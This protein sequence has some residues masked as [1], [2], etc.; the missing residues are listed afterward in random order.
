MKTEQL[1]AEIDQILNRRQE[2]AFLR[3]VLAL[4]VA[5]DKIWPAE[6]KVRALDTRDLIADTADIG[7]GM[8]EKAHALITGLY[9]TYFSWNFNDPERREEACKDICADL[10]YIAAILWAADG[11]LFE[12]NRD[13]SA[14]LG[15]ETGPVKAFVQNTRKL[16]GEFLDEAAQEEGAAEC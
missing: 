15:V 5:A 11:L 13:M 7:S 12:Y 16:Y 3:H 9:E 4:V 2:A 10:E 6:M 1:L 14:A 8:L